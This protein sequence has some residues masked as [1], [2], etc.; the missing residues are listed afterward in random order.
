MQDKLARME[1]L[2]MQHLGI[3]PHVPPTPRTSPSPVAERSG[4]QSDDQPGHL[5]TYIAPSQSAHLDD[6]Q[7]GH[8]TDPH[9]RMSEDQRH[10]LD[11]HDVFRYVHRWH[12]ILVLLIENELTWLFCFCWLKALG[13][14]NILWFDWL[15]SPAPEA[16]IRALEVLYALGVLDDV[17]NLTSPIGFQV[18]EIPLDMRS[19][20]KWFYYAHFDPK[21]EAIADFDRYNH[22]ATIAREVHDQ[23]TL[24]EALAELD[25]IPPPPLPPRM[26]IE[27][28]YKANG[29]PLPR[30]PSFDEEPRID[31]FP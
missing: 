21:E 25:E 1:A 8:W 16:M 23:L 31:L 27:E 12:L 13:I 4:P 24:E 3:R 15:A 17:A 28:L 2:L 5:T 18:S 14:D 20:W 11:E 6:H 30:S 7:P 22:A 29:V 10:L 26:W 9:R 19:N